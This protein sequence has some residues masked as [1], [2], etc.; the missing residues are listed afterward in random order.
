MRLKSRNANDRFSQVDLTADTASQSTL[1]ARLDQQAWRSRSS[2]SVN[3]SLFTE[4][5]LFYS[6]ILRSKTRNRPSFSKSVLLPEPTRAFRS[7]AR[8]SLR[9]PIWPVIVTK[10]WLASQPASSN[11]RNRKRPI[12]LDLSSRLDWLRFHRSVRRR[13]VSRH[14]EHKTGSFSGARTAHPP[15][16]TTIRIDWFHY[17]QPGRSV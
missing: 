16:K 5:S 6:T 9:T 7:C 12:Y 17:R 14:L 10:S 2:N 8:P 15:A 13:N 11:N 4:R 3:S 1:Q